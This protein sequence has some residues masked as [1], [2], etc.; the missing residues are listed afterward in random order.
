M[1]TV[2]A[3]APTT[4]EG[5]KAAF[6]AAMEALIAKHPAQEAN[7]E[8]YTARCANA[9]IARLTRRFRSK[10]GFTDVP[11]GTI[12]LDLGLHPMFPEETDHTFFM[13]KADGSLACS[14]V[15]ASWLKIV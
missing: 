6:T 9:R 14:L 4:L 11:K 13:P 3:N 5:L 1:S 10:G 8:S 7:R 12:V 2:P 15:P